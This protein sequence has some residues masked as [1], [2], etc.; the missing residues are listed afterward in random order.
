VP[1]VICAPKYNFIWSFDSDGL[2]MVGLDTPKGYKYG[3]IN[4]EGCEQ[5]E[6]KYDHV[7][8][9]E[10]GLAVAKLGGYY[11][12]INEQDEEVVPFEL[13]YPDMRGLR[14]GYATMKDE[15]GKWGAINAKGQVV[16]PCEYDSLVIFD[17]KGIARVKKGGK[18]F[19]IDTQ[20]QIVG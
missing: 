9:F 10:N 15:Y 8:S 14:N 18:E 11:G 4:F 16:I 3:Y 19:L 5:I 13:D 1:S 20:E 2:C 12:I 7:Y 6:V 17:E